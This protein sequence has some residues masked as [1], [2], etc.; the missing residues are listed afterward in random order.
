MNEDYIRIISNGTNELMKNVKINMSL[1]GWPAASSLIAGAIC[2]STVIISG[3]KT[4]EKLE[5]YQLSVLQQH[6]QDVPIHQLEATLQCGH[7]YI[8][9]ED[10]QR[11]NLQ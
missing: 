2:I 3:I 10:H 8:L 4:Y 1:I 5:S 9:A 7:F 11:H 6:Y